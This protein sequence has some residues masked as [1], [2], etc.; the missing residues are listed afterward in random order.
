[1]R[2][3]RR[4]GKLL[5]SRRTQEGKGGTPMRS[6][7]FGAM[8]LVAA[9]ASGEAAAQGA[10]KQAKPIPEGANEVIGAAIDGK[11]YVYGGQNPTSDA[12][13]ILWA[14]DPKED[15][16]TKLKGNPVPVHH[17]AAAAL[18]SKL[19]VFGGFHLPEGAKSG[20]YPEKNAWVYDTQTQ[21]WS[22]LPP[23]PTPRGALAA[24]AVGSKIYLSGG[25]KIPEGTALP[26]GLVCGGP[27]EMTGA[28]EAF[29][30]ET[31]SWTTLKP[32]SL[33]RNHHD[34]AAVDGKIYVMGGR[35]GSSYSG[36]C[37]TNVTLTEI[38]DIASD[39][40]STGAP[41]P[42][43]RSGLVAA[44][45]DGKIHVL[46]GE[47]WVDDFGGVFR[48]HEVYDPKTNSWSR[49]ARMPTPR[50]GFAK[51]VVDGK[52][53]AVSGVNNAGGAGTL[54]VVSVNEV[55]TP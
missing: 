46:G 24:V 16:W 14:Y 1:L 3:R 28:L 38:Y 20:W 43:A 42:T 47:G 41:M 34:L 31:N 39:T 26:G 32:M 22:A 4:D 11:V 13:G 5:P 19:Y 53:Y 30:V 49:G 12:M 9:L 37:S 8:A 33:P 10:W 52:L 7:W 18:G 29:D 35:V 50:H 51:A 27:I 40:W 15:A 55:F 48:T 2:E 45:L 6:I 36:G 21:A 54:S 17:G 23:M 44:A 25:A